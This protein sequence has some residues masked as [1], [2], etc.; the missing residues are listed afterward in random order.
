[1][2]KITSLTKKHITNI[3]EKKFIVVMLATIFFFQETDSVFSAAECTFDPMIDCPLSVTLTAATNPVPSGGNT[4]VSSFVDG[5]F[6]WGFVEAENFYFSI[7]YSGSMS[8]TGGTVV[9]NTGAIGS[10]LIV[11]TSVENSEG[12]FASDMLAVNVTAPPTVN[13]NFSFL[14]KVRQFFG[15]TFSKHGDVLALEK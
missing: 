11:T 5:I 9:G 4:N 10:T 12:V 3:F 1:M 2:K 6:Q 14:D 15:N 8:G 13:I 7:S